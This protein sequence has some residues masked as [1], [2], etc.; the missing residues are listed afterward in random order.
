MKSTPQTNDRFSPTLIAL[1]RGVV[2][3]ED[4]GVVWQHMLNLRS[5]LCDHLEPMGLLL[6]IDED[7][8]YALLR[9]RNATEG[10]D[11]PRLIPRRPLSYPVSLLLVLLRKK[12]AEADASGGDRRAVM[13]R[14]ELVDLLRQ[15]FNETTN[16]A[17][18]V[19]RLE[20]HINKVK[21]MGFLRQLK[22]REGEYEVVRLLKS[23]VDAEWLEK[24]QTTF[25]SHAA[26]VGKE[27]EE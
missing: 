6:E 22:G 23:F 21:E 25:R 10:D 9:Q 15:F 13:K 5:R 24:L 3:R 17:K 20:S 2:W 26:L 4:D 11:I 8:G 18:L 1:L 16:D 12:L 27:L 7:E 19:D 14:E